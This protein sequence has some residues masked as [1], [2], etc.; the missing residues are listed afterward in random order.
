MKIKPKQYAIALMEEL[1]NKKPAQITT[2]T[3]NF[4]GLLAVNNDLGLAEKIIAEFNK[5][6][7]KKEGIVEGEIIL[8]REPNKKI[9]EEIS[10]YIKQI[11]L[12]KKVLLTEKIDAD[13][14][15][16]AVVRY[17]DRVVDMSLKNRM[18]ELMGYIIS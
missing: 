2:A 11:T 16:G 15:G 17:G 12:A 7:N 9:L 8:A 1:E 10:D 3:D 4:V 6:R 13:I 5:I 18:R 14:L